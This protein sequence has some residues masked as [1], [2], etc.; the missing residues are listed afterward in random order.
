MG[1]GE[2]YPNLPLTTYPTG[3]IELTYPVWTYPAFEFKR[4]SF[5]DIA[6]ERPSI[7]D[8][9]DYNEGSNDISDETRDR[10]RDLL[11]YIR[12]LEDKLSLGVVG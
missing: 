2:Y 10:M 5:G 1:F 7:E 12:L 4:V 9:S 11:N 3:H 8:I 6:K